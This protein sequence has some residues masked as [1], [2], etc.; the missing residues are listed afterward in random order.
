ML[1]QKCRAPLKLHATL[2][3]LNPASFNLLA[4]ST[5]PPQ[6]PTPLS[7]LPYPSDQ[8]KNYD[9]AVRDTKGTV[10]SR[11]GSEQH[12]SGPPSPASSRGVD[13]AAMSFINVTDSQ[14]V[15]Q[16]VAQK[17]ALQTPPRRKSILP[18]RKEPA[19]NTASTTH[20]EASLSQRMETS[21]RLFEILSSRTDI[22][23]PICTE[24]TDLLITGM[25]KRLA[26][27]TKER[28]SYLDFLKNA[29]AEMPTDDEAKETQRELLQVKGQEAAALKELEELESEKATMEEELAALAL[30]S[31]QLEA[32]EEAF[33][34]D[35]NAVVD[36]IRHL[37]EEKES[38]EL[39]YAH[40]ERL[41]ADLSR[42][43]VYNDAFNIS[44]AGPRGVFA[45][46]NNL[47]MGRTQ[48]IKVE[49][50]E[51]NAAWGMTCLLLA[52]VA[53]KLN[54]SFQGYCLNPLGS[55]SSID[56]IK[57][58]TPKS[59]ITG[60]ATSSTS[61]GSQAQKTSTTNYP[62]FYASELPIDL[63]FM[64]KRFSEGIVHF[65][66]CVSQLGRHVSKVTREWQGGSLSIPC[67]IE[68]DKIRDSR[69]GKWCS[70]KLVSWDE[71]TRAC[72]YLLTDCKMLLAVMV[73]AERREAEARKGT[74][75]G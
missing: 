56:E 3:N 60:S 41:L 29:R 22:D 9:D 74:V 53:D 37:E 12:G 48:D 32:E 20:Q 23:H 54:Y 26:N 68:G 40:D 62:L 75:S 4:D 59:S 34:R 67:V 14:I 51:I 66:Q 18:G 13:K 55:T 52:T 27:A 17:A 24:C 2:Q 44:H 73:F 47:R 33:W 31:K 15:P 43:N 63:P 8:K 58:V 46:I 65:A 42:V 11:H 30:E 57:S 72:K 35:R 6:G 21:N 38:L 50:A 10:R 19:A 5:P 70:I 69:G 61:T 7:R 39:R 49:W 71:W 45:T 64:H 16:A 28:D 1:C 25:E 36:S